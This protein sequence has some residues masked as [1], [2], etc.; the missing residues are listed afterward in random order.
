MNKLFIQQISKN[1][2]F[3]STNILL[4]NFSD[5]L[6]AGA[7]NGTFSDSG[8]KRIVTD[9]NNKLSMASGN[10]S[11]ATGSAGSGDP[12]FYYEPFIR[13]EGM[14]LLGQGSVTGSGLEFGWDT[15]L[16]GAITNTVSYTHLTLPTNREV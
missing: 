9:T 3:N 15:V 7:I 5:T 11:F 6:G 4:D 10:L 16:G 1:Y 12:Y 8:H 14:V 13:G 2:R